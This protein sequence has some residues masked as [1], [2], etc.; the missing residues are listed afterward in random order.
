MGVLLA[1]RE[2]VADAGDAGYTAH[3]CR[4]APTTEGDPNPNANS[5]ELETLGYLRCSISNCLTVRLT[6][7]PSAKPPSF[8]ETIPSVG[9]IWG[10]APLQH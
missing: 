8:P 4:T 9:S 10:Q 2:R 3:V 6:D 5:A 1:S 7:C